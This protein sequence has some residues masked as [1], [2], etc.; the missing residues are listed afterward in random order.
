MFDRLPRPRPIR[1]G[2]TPGER[3]M[4]RLKPPPCSTCGQ[5][6][7]RVTLRTDYYL[8]LRCEQCGSVWSVTKPGYER[9]GT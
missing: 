9:Y 6:H 8:Y 4:N 1:A 3:R 7:C 2:L 5:D